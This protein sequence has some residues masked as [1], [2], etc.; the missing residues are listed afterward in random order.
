MLGTLVSA[1]RPTGSTVL[2]GGRL[3]TT[4]AQWGVD[5]VV[6][7]LVLCNSLPGRKS[8]FRAGCQP[9]A[10]RES[11]QIGPPAGRRPAGGLILKLSRLES[12]LNPAQEPDFLPGSTIAQHRVFDFSAPWGPKVYVRAYR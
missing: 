10:S 11:L 8:G 12:G 3:H 7:Y 1:C 5:R 4:T 2:G 9:D 6:W